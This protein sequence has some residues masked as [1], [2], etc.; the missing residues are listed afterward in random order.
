MEAE[1]NMRSGSMSVVSR[2]EPRKSEE[3]RSEG[4]VGMPFSC[5]LVRVAVAVVRLWRTEGVY[6]VAESL[7]VMETCLVRTFV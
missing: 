6:V 2:L 5:C 4:D 3:R 1:E 7:V